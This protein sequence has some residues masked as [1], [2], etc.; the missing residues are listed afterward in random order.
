MAALT[1]PIMA[2]LVELVGYYITRQTAVLA[3]QF[4]DGIWNLLLPGIALAGTGM[5][6]ISYIRWVK[7]SL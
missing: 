6:V 1:I 7:W 2:L 4:G 5:V 3:F